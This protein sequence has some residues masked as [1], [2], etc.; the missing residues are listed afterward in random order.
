MSESFVEKQVRLMLES[1]CREYA[2]LL[3]TKMPAGVGFALFLFD[4][5]ADGNV[6][7]VSTARREDM[8]R[9]VREWL[10]RTEARS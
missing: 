6:A 5:G 2:N 10:A 4:F 8:I 1:Q 3:R 9:L 7:Y